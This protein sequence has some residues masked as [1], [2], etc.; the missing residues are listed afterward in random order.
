MINLNPLPQQLL[1]STASN[2]AQMEFDSSMPTS[3]NIPTNML[4]NGGVSVVLVFALAY[5]T[6]VL[7]QSVGQLI[8]V[9]KK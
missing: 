5:F 1:A 9:V 4:V 3:F 6:R 2:R 8:K 7:L